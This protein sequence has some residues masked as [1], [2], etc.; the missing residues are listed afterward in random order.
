MKGQATPTISSTTAHVELNQENCTIPK[1][2]PLRK[3]QEEEVIVP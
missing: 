3:G 2:S 1:K